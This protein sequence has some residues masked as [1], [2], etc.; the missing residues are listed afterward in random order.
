MSYDISDLKSAQSGKFEALLMEF[1][2]TGSAQILWKFIKKPSRVDFSNVAN[3]SSVPTHAAKVSHR[4]YGYT[5]G[6]TWKISG[7]SIHTF[8]QQKSLSPVY[9]GLMKLLEAKENYDTPLL[10]FRMGAREF[11]PCKLTEVSGSIDAWLSGEIAGLTDLALTLVRVPAPLAPAQ[12]EARER[13]QKEQL[14]SLAQE[15]L[16]PPTK[17]SDRLQ[18]EAKAKAKEYLLKHSALWGDSIQAD[19]KQNKFKLSVDPV[20]GDVTLLSV[21]GNLSGVVGRFDGTS[22]STGKGL[23]TILL[24]SKNQTPP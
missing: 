15:Q 18:L 1:S 5:D 13:S 21:T 11:A 10:L 24:K 20:K 6:E 22:L 3:H 17:L 16:R 19:L 12:K 8:W 2:P 4:H 7:L 23:T 9:D 14:A